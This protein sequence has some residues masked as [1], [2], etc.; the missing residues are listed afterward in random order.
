MVNSTKLRI[1][2][3]IK[4]FSLITISLWINSVR[5]INHTFKIIVIKKRYAVAY[6]LM[7]DSTT[8]SDNWDYF[9]LRNTNPIPIADTTTGISQAALACTSTK[10]RESVSI[11]RSFS[12]ITWL[13]EIW[14]NRYADPAFSAPTSSSCAPTRT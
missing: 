6:D 8:V 12:S 11:G 1:K 5:T 7:E 9:L 14:V 2:G 13:V 4:G 10:K 3:M